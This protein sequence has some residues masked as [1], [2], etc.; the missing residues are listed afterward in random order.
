MN[1]KLLLLGILK[2]SE[3]HGYQLYDF[4]ERNLAVCTDLK[5]ASAYFLLNKME[6]EGYI[7]A[8]EQRVGNRPPR[9]VY[10]LT[11]SGEQ[12][13][14]QL[15]VENLAQ[16]TPPVF[17]DDIGIAFL[18]QLPAERA[19]ALLRKRFQTMQLRLRE[20]ENI[21]PHPGATALLIQH[22]IHHLQ[23]EIA[24]LGKL[25]ASLEQ[26]ASP[27]RTPRREGIPDCESPS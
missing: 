5:K 4:I 10:R 27:A 19:L 2:Q 14:E 15:L 7:Q 8:V 25:I 20:L 22:Q 18:D 16:Y 6:K 13:F 23:S 1:A 17:S 11:A 9:K 21:P 12:L 26:G 24:W 3:M